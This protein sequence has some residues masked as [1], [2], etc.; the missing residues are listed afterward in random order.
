MQGGVGDGDAA[1]FHRAQPRHRGNGAG[2]ADLHVNRLHHGGF[3]HRREFPGNRPARRARDE[4]RRLLVAIAVGLID[5][6]VDFIGQ[7]VPLLPQFLHVSGGGGDAAEA[8]LQRADRHAPGGVL[9]EQVA[10]GGGQGIAVVRAEAVGEKA[11]LAAGGNGGVKLAQAARGGI[12]RIGKSL[13]AVTLRRRI[14]RGKSGLRHIHLAPDVDERRRRVVE[15]AQRDGADGAHIGGDVLAGRTVATGRRAGEDA[16]LITQADGKTVELR[17]GG[18]Q[19]VVVVE[20]LL[21]A[22]DE[23]GKFFFAEDVIQRQHRYVVRHRGK[24]AVGLAADAAGRRIGGD[25]YAAGGFQ[26]AQLAHQRIVFGV[27]NARIIK[28]IVGVVVRADFGAQGGDAVGVGHGV[29]AHG[30]F[31]YGQAAAASRHAV[32]RRWFLAAVACRCGR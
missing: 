30:G 22:P 19:Q 25:G 27:G 7:V 8:F 6:A 9:R 14:E 31:S 20:P 11:Q 4:A 13:A 32:R 15:Q 10:V 1:D 3:L 21:Q 23:S 12:A 26:R 29:I 28:D 5:N 16:M 18:Q 17:L 24:R 2:A